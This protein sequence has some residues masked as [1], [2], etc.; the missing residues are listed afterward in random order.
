M[1]TSYALV[2]TNNYDNEAIAEHF[3]AQHI[4]NR[5]EG[6]CMLIALRDSK[7]RDD[8]D[9]YKLVASDYQLWRGMAEFVDGAEDNEFV[10]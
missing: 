9:W 7:Q 4:P 3:V 1:S 8:S 10:E 2:R 5:T 6:L